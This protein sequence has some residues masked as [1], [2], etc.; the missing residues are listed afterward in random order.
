MSLFKF[1]NILRFSLRPRGGEEKILIC[2]IFFIF[3]MYENVSVYA[4]MHN[5]IC[6]YIYLFYCDVRGKML[7]WLPLDVGFSCDK[8]ANECHPS[9]FAQLSPGD[10]LDGC[11]MLVI[12]LSFPSFLIGTRVE[13]PCKRSITCEKLRKQLSPLT[14]NKQR[15]GSL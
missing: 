15:N 2:M 7:S 11:Q 4:P 8:Q 3:L 9:L 5:H 14:T 10:N 6:R 12:R 1:I 13:Y